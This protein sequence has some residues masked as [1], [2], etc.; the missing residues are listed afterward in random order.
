MASIAQM[1]KYV[2]YLEQRKDLLARKI[3]QL[4]VVKITSKLIPVNSEYNNAEIIAPAL[5][6]KEVVWEYDSVC[7]EIRLV[8]DEIERLNHSTMSTLELNF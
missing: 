6:I 4:E 2:P 7:K 5:N 8:K 1:L 3:S